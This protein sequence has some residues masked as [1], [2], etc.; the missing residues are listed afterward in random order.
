[1]SQALPFVTSVFNKKQIWWSCRSSICRIYCKAWRLCVWVLTCCNSRSPFGYRNYS[2]GVWTLIWT[3][4]GM[5]KGP[6]TNTKEEQE[7][8][9]FLWHSL[10]YARS[11][12]CVSSSNTIRMMSLHYQ[13]TNLFA[14]QILKAIWNLK[15]K[16]QKQTSCI[17]LTIH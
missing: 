11:W 9:F 1:M 5:M 6:S 7:F 2:G 14:C 4:T 17:T 8:F 13:N 16:C 15:K 12:A 3:F 10:P